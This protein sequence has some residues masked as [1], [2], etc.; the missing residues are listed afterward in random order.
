MDPLRTAESIGLEL[1]ALR[2]EHTLQANLIIRLADALYMTPAERN[3][4]AVLQS[5]LE[6]VSAWAAG[7]TPPPLV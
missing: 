6:E 1:A 7:W 3:V 2:V 5:E 4:L